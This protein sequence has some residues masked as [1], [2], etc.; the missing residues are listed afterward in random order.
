MEFAALIKGIW[1]LFLSLILALTPGGFP[2]V[3]NE[4]NLD[5]V[6]SDEFD[7]DALDASKWH[8][9]YC[10]AEATIRRGSYWSTDMAVV[11]DGCLHIKTQYLPEGLN[12]NGKPGWYTCGIDTSGLYE[13]TFGYFEVRCILPKGSG[14]WSA[15]WMLS[16]GMGQVGN[17]GEDGA[18]IDIFESPFYGER[19]SR[20][21]SSNIH[22][23]GYGADLKSNH[24]CEAYLLRN[25]PYET[26][27]TYGLEWNEK[28]YIFYVNGIE[29]GRSSFGGTAKVPEFMILS[30]EV[31]GENAEPGDSWAGAS[32]APGDAPTDFVI[33]YVRAYQYKPAE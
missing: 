6:W 22:I 26:F 5:L 2:R 3:P 18:E 32:L 4:E 1:S 20:R 13:Q 12:G 10:S 30:V 15:F 24:V 8:G 11:E 27:N 14:L 33:D 19:F 17:G 7:G 29:T 9:H 16:N 28:E 25:D 21:V 23:D 31:G